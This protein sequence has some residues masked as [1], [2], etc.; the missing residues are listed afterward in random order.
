MGVSFDCPLKQPQ[1]GHPPQQNTAQITM[2]NYSSA[3]A[4][5]RP[6]R[7]SQRSPH[8]HKRL[9]KCSVYHRMPILLS[10][11]TRLQKLRNARKQGMPQRAS[12]AHILTYCLTGFS[13]SWT[14]S[15]GPLRFASP[16]SA[17]ANLFGFAGPGWRNWGKSGPNVFGNMNECPAHP[18]ASMRQL[19]ASEP[20][21]LLTN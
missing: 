16:L 12:R 9:A 1:Q 20:T 3:L 14:H 7:L 11:E 6:K 5:K 4:P 13:K 21:L 10:F 8:K 18:R 15:W 2:F 17:Y 19:S